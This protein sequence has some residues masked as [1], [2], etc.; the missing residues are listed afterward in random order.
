MEA[1]SDSDVPDRSVIV[2]PAPTDYQSHHSVGLGLGL[3]LLDHTLPSPG[4]SS[5]MMTDNDQEDPE[6]RDS[7]VD[8]GVMQDPQ[9]REEVS[10]ISTLTWSGK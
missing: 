7:G 4:L 6:A 5:S 2:H 3:P 10:S 9:D 1:R 8:A